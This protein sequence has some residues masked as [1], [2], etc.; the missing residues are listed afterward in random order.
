MAVCR[1]YIA[2]AGA[3]S[4]NGISSRLSYAGKNARVA[5]SMPAQHL[6]ATKI[7][8]V[9]IVAKSEG[10]A[11]GTYRYS[12]F[13]LQNNRGSMLGVA[14]RNFENIKATRL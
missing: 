5:R 2:S 3:P 7:F 10:C 13:Q 6:A 8:F 14:K 1:R 4:R 9:I 11:A 12:I